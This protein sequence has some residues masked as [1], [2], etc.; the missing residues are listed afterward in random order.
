MTPFDWTRGRLRSAAASLLVICAAQLL[1]WQNP[2]AVAGETI[3]LLAASFRK[4]STSPDTIL[5]NH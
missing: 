5:T 3:S 1:K 2:A 4:F